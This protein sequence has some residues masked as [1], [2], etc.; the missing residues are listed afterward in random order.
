MP[1]NSNNHHTTQHNTKHCQQEFIAEPEEP[2]QP[3]YHL[4]THRTSNNII[5]TNITNTDNSNINNYNNTSRLTCKSFSKIRVIGI[6]LSAINI[7]HFKVS[8]MHGTNDNTNNNI[9][10]SN[11]LTKD[12]TEP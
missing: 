12:Y 6:L 5:N 10:T 7:Q 2:H 3:Q 1:T 11:M 8:S 9:N 4:T